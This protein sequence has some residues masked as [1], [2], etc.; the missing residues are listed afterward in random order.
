MTD[1]LWKVS[2]RIVLVGIVVTATVALLGV[3]RLKAASSSSADPKAAVELVVDYGDGVEKRFKS[4][5]WSQNMTVLDA[6]NAAKSSPH[7]ITF[8]HRGSGDSVFLLK[9]D[10][11]GN[12]GGG[13]GKRNWLYEVNGKLGNKSCGIFQVAEGDRI[14]WTFGARVP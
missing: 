9:I 7:G 10:D 2:R 12:E 6:L 14:V 5:P 11:L 13:K 1:R 4:L 8:E 3:F